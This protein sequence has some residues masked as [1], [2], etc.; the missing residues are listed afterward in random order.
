MLWTHQVDIAVR[1]AGVAGAIAIRHPKIAIAAVA[2]PLAYKYLRPV[3]PPK[4]K[5]S[6]PAHTK[7]L[8]W[9]VEFE[10]R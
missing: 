10:I 7:H 5:V 6:T 8:G 9:Y 3:R 2:A 4:L 1:A